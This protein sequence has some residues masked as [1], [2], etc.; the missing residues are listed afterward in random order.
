MAS[1]LWDVLDYVRLPGATTVVTLDPKRISPIVRKRAEK[2]METLVVT[3]GGQSGARHLVHV[4]LPPHVP[5]ITSFRSHY[6]GTIRSPGACER[7][8]HAWLDELE[9]ATR[10][11]AKL[12]P[13]SEI[14]AH[15]EQDRAGLK[16]CN[17]QE[18]KYHHFRTLSN[19]TSAAQFMEHIAPLYQAEIAEAK[20]QLASTELI[21]VQ[22]YHREPR[23]RKPKVAP[24]I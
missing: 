3:S 13:S 24:A 19:P 7:Q 1:T 5:L 22:T 15:I 12:V 8:L 2:A 21:T 9:E 14:L 17:M 4:L 20:R 10:I 11:A 18:R 6:W 16:A 23:R